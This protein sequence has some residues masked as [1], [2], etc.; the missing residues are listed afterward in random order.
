MEEFTKAATPLRPLK[1]QDPRPCRICGDNRPTIGMR[2]LCHRHAMRWYGSVHN[3]RFA[4]DEYADWLAL[5]EPFEALGLCRV[6]CCD[7]QAALHPGLCADHHRQL[8]RDGFPGRQMASPHQLDPPYD[9]EV[10]EAWIEDQIPITRVGRINLVGL[11]PLLKAELKYGLYAHSVDRDHGWW[12]AHWVQHLANRYRKVASLMEID[13]SSASHQNR[14]VMLDMLSSLR[15]VMTTKSDTRS[16]GYIELDHFGLR[17]GNRRSQFDLCNISQLW[18][19][20]L[21]WD[22]IAAQL[23]DPAGARSAS[24]YDT[25]RR[26]ISDLSAYLRHCAPNGGNDLELLG[27]EHAHAFATDQRVRM[28]NGLQALSPNLMTGEPLPVTPNTVRKTLTY[29][30][31]LMQW[32]LNEGHADE[33]GLRTAF[34]VAF[35]RADKVKARIRNPFSDDVA[36][37]VAD[38]ANLTLLHNKWDAQNRGVRDIWE[39]IVFTGRRVGEVL[40]LRIDCI[41]RYNGLPLLWH[42]QTKVANYGEAVRIPEYIYRKLELRQ[43]MTKRH[44]EA[45]FGRPPTSAEIK[46]L[47]LFPSSVR[48]PHL[49]RSVSYR[50]FLARF[51][52]WIDELDLGDVV[53]HQAR[54]TIA[55][56]LL[57]AG[58][59]MRQIKDYLGHVSERMSEHYAKITNSDLEEALQTVW[60]AGP[61]SRVPGERLS[62]LSPMTR[63]EAQ[64]IAIDLSRKSTPAEGGFCTFQPVVD[65]GICPWKLDCTNCEHFVI[66]GADLLYWR[67]K[68]E[69]WTLIAERAPDDATTEYLHD[70]FAPTAQA[71]DGLE[72]ALGAL[73]LLDDALALD[74][75]RPQDYFN[76]LWGTTFR[77]TDL[78]P[79]NTQAD[80][81]GGRT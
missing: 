31:R 33:I 11:A 6:P 3:G 73:G 77:P 50:W 62:G 19:R 68:R 48:N 57:A 35:P 71:I 20:N 2:E 34:I 21:L 4:K 13:Q 53:T 76:R 74:L 51:Q 49:E 40:N 16:A 17:F 65:G 67:R 22:Y 26:S 41:G 5:Q 37:A 55:T 69:Q 27:A 30:R 46:T 44:F 14:R 15:L 43:Q 45:R 47:A 61:G 32:A 81:E 56:K 7:T 42:D 70:V 60:V 9:S 8:Q 12:G 63:A 64:R 80:A 10:F 58:A 38:E 39:T 36:R 52:E 59:S 72:R 28:A 23:E 1:Q 54:H 66:S 25:V 78:L 75:R 29:V 79:S 24:P 18:L